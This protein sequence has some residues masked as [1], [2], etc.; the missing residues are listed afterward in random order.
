[1][2]DLKLIEIAISLVGLVGAGVAFFFGLRQY[3]RSE[4]WKRAEFVT[5][6]MKE[7]FAGAKVIDRARHALKTC[8]PS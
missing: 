7:F 3:R 4:Q 8:S 1:M 2:P 6:E 5:A